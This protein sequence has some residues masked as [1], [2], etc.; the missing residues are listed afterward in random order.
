MRPGKDGQPVAATGVS[1]WRTKG[2]PNAPP[3]AKQVCHCVQHLLR[4]S[5]VFEGIDG[6][7]QIG[8]RVRFFREDASVRYT[9]CL[10]SSPGRGEHRFADI[11]ANDSCGS[12]LGHLDGV[13]AFPTAEV[14]DRFLPD[15][16][17]SIWAKDIR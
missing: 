5:E 8:L 3:R 1:P 7:D 15:R 6:D 9:S 14:N 2:N 13:K 17:P 11:N 10:S 12:A 16:L 4:I